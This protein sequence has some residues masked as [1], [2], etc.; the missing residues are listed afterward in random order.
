MIQSDTLSRRPD[1]EEGEDKGE[2]ITLF[3][4]FKFIIVIN[5]SL[6]DKIQTCTQENHLAQTVL[7]G[8]ENPIALPFKS[9]KEDWRYEDGILLYKKQ[10]YIS[11]NITLR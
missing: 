3:L 7:K 11:A 4:K 8:L 2:V 9:T 6:R 1:H 5:L 10:L